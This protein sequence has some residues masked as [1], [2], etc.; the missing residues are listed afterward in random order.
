MM[1]ID[2]GVVS[3]RR[4]VI[5]PRT[6]E[7]TQGKTYRAPGRAEAQVIFTGGSNS[8]V[9]VPVCVGPGETLH[10]SAFG[11]CDD[12]EIEAWKA[13]PYASD[14][15]SGTSC[16]AGCTD[17]LT[18]LPCPEVQF[19]RP[20]REC[21]ETVTMALDYP[22]IQLPGPG[23]YQMVVTSKHVPCELYVE[24]IKEKSCCG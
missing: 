9:S 17:K 14:T 20:F 4:H 5:E 7:F 23:C 16:E 15:P 18:V 22:D 2:T 6:A 10:V 24:A 12:T 1:D 19:A 13:I 21:G 3:T 8:A 11:L